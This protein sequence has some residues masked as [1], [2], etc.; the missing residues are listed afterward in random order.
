MSNATLTHK[1]ETTN[2]S[3]NIN[4]E[5]AN[6]SVLVFLDSSGKFIDDRITK[7][8]EEL[9]YEGEEGEIRE[10]IIDYLDENWDKLV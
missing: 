8:E 4:H 10:A 6:Y 3:F 1:D 5:G 2:Y 9:G 7:D